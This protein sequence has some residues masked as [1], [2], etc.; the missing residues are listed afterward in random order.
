MVEGH[1]CRQG[2]EAKTALNNGHKMECIHCNEKQ[3]GGVAIVYKTTM[4]IREEVN[5]RKFPTFE[6]KIWTKSKYCY[7]CYL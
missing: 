4:K 7:S 6:I 3:G 1:R 5:N 2:M